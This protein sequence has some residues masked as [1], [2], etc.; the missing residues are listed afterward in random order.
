MIGAEDSQYTYE[1]LEHFKILPAIHE[2]DKDANRIKVGKKVAEGFS[3][4]SDNNKL[5]MSDAELRIWIESNRE[6]IGDI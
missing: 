6:K 2:W 4:T 5:W 3:Y 1:Y